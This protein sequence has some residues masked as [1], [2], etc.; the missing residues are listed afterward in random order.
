MAAEL[1]PLGTIGTAEYAGGIWL[2]DWDHRIPSQHAVLRLAAYYTAEGH[3][4][5]E[6]LIQQRRA[7]I[8]KDDL[9]P[10]VD[11]GDFPGLPPEAPH[12]P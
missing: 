8:A 6:A 1:R 7:D 9:F 5:G 11:V 3:R 4:Q 2:L 10:A 12:E